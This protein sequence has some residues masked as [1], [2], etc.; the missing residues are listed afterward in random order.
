MTHMSVSI[1]GIDKLEKELQR[2]NSVRFDSVVQLQANEMVNRAT[3]SQ[4]PS[5]GGTPRDTGD[6]IQSVN[7]HG[8]GADAEV[9]YTKE[10]ALQ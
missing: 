7:M 6:L 1:K 2:M 3:A 8:K 10:Y 5:L 9:G 4:N